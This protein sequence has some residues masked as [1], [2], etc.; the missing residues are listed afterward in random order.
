MI[1]MYLYSP[2]LQTL[3]NKKLEI[4]GRAKSTSTSPY[5]FR[6]VPRLTI[7]DEKIVKDI[8]VQNQ[9]PLFLQN[10]VSKSS[11]IIYGDSS[12]NTDLYP[13]TNFLGAFELMK[14]NL[15]GHQ[16]VDYMDQI[17]LDFIVH[18]DGCHM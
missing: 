15:I 4:L 14:L 7:S 16:M 12:I 17:Q 5:T 1:F 18:L 8:L 10:N 13:I 3:K 11:S 6:N 9:N 2:I